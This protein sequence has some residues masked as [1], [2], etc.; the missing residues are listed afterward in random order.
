MRATRAAAQVG[1]FVDR[2]LA[3][4]RDSTASYLDELLLAGFFIKEGFHGEDQMELYDT[5]CVPPAMRQEPRIPD[6]DDAGVSGGAGRATRRI[7]VVDLEEGGRLVGWVGDTIAADEV[8]IGKK[9]QVVP[10]I[11]EEEE[12]I[13]V[14]YTVDQPG[15]AWHK[16]PAPHRG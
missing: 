12:Q 15:T 8:A 9:V 10:R 2:F 6:F 7:A 14:Y 3:Y 1:Q 13:K 4:S 11:F 5:T 16:A